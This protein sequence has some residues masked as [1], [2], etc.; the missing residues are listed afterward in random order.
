MIC[1][2]DI[3][4]RL[5]LDLLIVSQIE[6]WIGMRIFNYTNI[7]L[8]NGTIIQIYN[9]TMILVC[10]FCVKNKE[11]IGRRMTWIGRMIMDGIQMLNTDPQ[12]S[13][14]V[15][16]NALSAEESPTYFTDD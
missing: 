5:D 9:G 8:F 14:H 11:R 1:C 10:V 6:F 7:Q 2:F 3:F 13:T 12:Q 4:N 16:P 15:I